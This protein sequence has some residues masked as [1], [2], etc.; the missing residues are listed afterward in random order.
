VGEVEKS[1]AKCKP[2]EKKTK[3]NGL[4][5]QHRNELQLALLCVG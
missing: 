5:Q 3:N 4:D 2:L 1:F